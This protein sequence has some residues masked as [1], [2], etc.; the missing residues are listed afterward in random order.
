ML[1]VGGEGLGRM[2]GACLGSGITAAIKVSA[3]KDAQASLGTAV[4][5]PLPLAGK[6]IK[7]LKRR[8]CT[9]VG[10][11]RSLGGLLLRAGAPPPRGHGHHIGNHHRL[12]GQPAMAEVIELGPTEE[13]PMAQGLEGFIAALLMATE[14][15]QP[16]HQG[17]GGALEGGPIGLGC[18]AWTED[19]QVCPSLHRRLEPIPQGR[20][21]GDG[22]GRHPGN[23]LGNGE[24]QP[25]IKTGGQQQLSQS[26]EL[27]LGATDAGIAQAGPGQGSQGKEAAIVEEKG[28]PHTPR[29]A[30]A[31][32]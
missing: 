7:A 29:M 2:A 30:G 10:Q 24:Q 21:H 25:E 11:I 15:A 27:V 5:N 28:H 20:H 14:V 12:V 16:G 19:Q 23:R 8:D 18:K 3:A 1:F 22:L 9:H 17:N 13:D 26:Q 6:P 4:R 32:Q 31:V